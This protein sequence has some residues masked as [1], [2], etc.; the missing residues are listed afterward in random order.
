MSNQY[1]DE[2]KKNDDLRKDF[3]P[4]QSHKKSGHKITGVREEIEKINTWFKILI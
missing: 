1:S 2:H 4:S 3:R